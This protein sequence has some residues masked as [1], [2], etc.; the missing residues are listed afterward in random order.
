[1]GV[2]NTLF[3]Y[4]VF[5]LFIYLGMHY[6][7]AALLGTVLGILFNFQ[8]IG[9]LVFNSYS[10]GLIFRFTAVYGA[11]Y[12]LNV[13]GLYFFNRAGINNYIAGAIL[14]FPVAVIAFN[15]NKLFVFPKNQT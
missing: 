6:S 1:V 14:I 12:L 7:L 11:T 2:L 5:A 9:R 13:V 10:R 4:G 15:L 8:T 3:G